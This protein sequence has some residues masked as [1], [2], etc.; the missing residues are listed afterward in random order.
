L[1]KAYISEWQ[2]ADLTNE[3]FDDTNG[4]ATWGTLSDLSVKCKKQYPL[5]AVCGSLVNQPIAYGSSLSSDTANTC[6][7]GKFKQFS[8][9]KVYSNFKYTTD[10]Y[11]IF[12]VNPNGTTQYER[13]K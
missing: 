3:K 9:S 4:L 6:S 8:A 13:Y 1:N 10:Y 5:K 7:V 2:N 11:H 12:N